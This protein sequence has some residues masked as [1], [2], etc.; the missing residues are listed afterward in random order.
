MVGHFVAG[1]N[2]M[3]V[4]RTEEDQ[5]ERLAFFFCIFSEK[6]GYEDLSLADVQN[7]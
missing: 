2:R 5:S 4:K 1:G 7:P 6:V 3:L